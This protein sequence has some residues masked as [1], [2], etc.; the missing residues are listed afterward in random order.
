MSETVIKTKEEWKKQ[1]TPEQYHILRE[2]GTEPAYTGIYANFHEHGIY[3][4]AACGLDLFGSEDKYDSGTGWPSFKKPLEAAEFYGAHRCGEHKYQT[5]Q[6]LIHS[7]HRG[8]LPPLRRPSRPC[9]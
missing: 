7:P 6:H 5:G 9:L 1:L 8:A 3:R 2:K 4:C